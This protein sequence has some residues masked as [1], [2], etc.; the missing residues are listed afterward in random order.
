MDR[1]ELAHGLMV[2]TVAMWCVMVLL[3]VVG[4]V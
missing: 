2:F 4:W 1:L 3:A